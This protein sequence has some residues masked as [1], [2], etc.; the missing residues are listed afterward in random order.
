M[1]ING[2]SK[3]SKTDISGYSP[4]IYY[5]NGNAD[6]DGDRGSLQNVDLYSIS[7]NLISQEDFSEYEDYT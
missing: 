2:N 6:D 3:L 7:K 5:N 1:A 4:G